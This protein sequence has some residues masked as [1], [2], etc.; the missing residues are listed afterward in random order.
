MAKLD[1]LGWAAGISFISQGVR[2]GVRVNKAEVLESLVERLPGGWKPTKKTVVEQL[3]SLKVGGVGTRP[4][5]RQF[6]L[7]YGNVNKLARTMS[8]DEVFA[9]FQKDLQHSVAFLAKHKVFVRAGVVG[10]Q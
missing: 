3:Y 1:R 2:I 6:N 7:L 10:W 9:A 8:L 4:Q 5:I